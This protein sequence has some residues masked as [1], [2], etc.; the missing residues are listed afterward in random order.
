MNCNIGKIEV[1]RYNIYDTVA[2]VREVRDVAFFAEVFIKMSKMTILL[3]SVKV[4]VASRSLPNKRKTY[5]FHFR[6]NKFN[7]NAN[8]PLFPFSI[9][10]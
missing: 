7:I 8:V 4:N 6:R 5:Y 10:L 9:A 2:P 3:Y 1:S